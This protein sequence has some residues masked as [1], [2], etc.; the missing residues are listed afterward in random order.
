MKIASK[1]L[2]SK[3]D[4]C[5]GVQLGNESVLMSIEK[6]EY[7]SL[8]PIGSRIWELLQTPKAFEQLC[9]QLEQEFNVD[10]DKFKDDV[11]GFLNEL[12]TEKFID[13]D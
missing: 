10:P 9:M 6:G 11:E 7:Y 5:V 2:I 3:T 4:N 13:L 1:T 8:D 12:I